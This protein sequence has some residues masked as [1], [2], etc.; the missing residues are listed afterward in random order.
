M[1]VNDTVHTVRVRFAVA[2]EK[3]HR[4]NGHFNSIG[5]TTQNSDSR[6]AL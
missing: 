5:F 6:L 3:S 2:S 1:D 4:V